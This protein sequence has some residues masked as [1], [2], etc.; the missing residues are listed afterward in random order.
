MA[1]EVDCDM[2]Y[3]PL[4]WNADGVVNMEEFSLFSRA[5]LTHDPNDPHIPAGVD[6]N[7][8]ARWNRKCNLDGDYDIDL[9]D[10]MIFADYR[11][12]N[13]LWTACWRTAL[14]QMHMNAMIPS[15]PTMGLTTESLDTPPALVP[16][17]ETPQKLIRE[18]IVEFKDTVQFL[19]R[20]WLTDDSIQTEIDAGEWRQFMEK[21]YQNMTDL[22]NI[23]NTMSNLK[24][25]ER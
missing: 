8:L 24:E 5:W 17:I 20:L 12:A 22:Q 16:Q 1:D 25:V 4:D 15:T 14:Q 7:D 23:E 19:E 10:L 6:P 3:H 2:V 13:W 18:Q 9:A 21:V 11:N